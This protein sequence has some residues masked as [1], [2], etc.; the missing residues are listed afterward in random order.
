MANLD[1]EIDIEGLNAIS[2]TLFDWNILK[3]LSEYIV[4]TE[5]VGRGHRGVVFKAFSDKYVDENG[6]H[7]ILAVKIPRLDTPKIT[8]PHEG[9]ILE[10]TNSFGVGPKIY[11]YS[12]THMVMEYVDGEM[13]KDC[14]DHLTP[15]EILFVVEETLRQCLRLDLH[16]IDHTEI[17]G[18]KH[19]MVSKKGIYIIDFDKAREHSPKNF[20]SAM[21]LLF[22]ENYISKKIM[23]LLNLSEE[24]IILFRKHAKNYK[25]LFKN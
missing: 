21:S 17:Q 2:S 4:F 5:Y 22:G 1:L 25:M 19:I 9:K 3:K 6:N 18:G 16:K 8:I 11:E 12:E 23:H 15:E 7:I 10:K 13:L 20:T 24:K 14:I